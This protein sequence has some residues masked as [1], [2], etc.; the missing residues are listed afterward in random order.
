MAGNSP[1]ADPD[2][3]GSS[4]QSAALDTGAPPSTPCRCP[5]S[6]VQLTN[7]F[8][9]VAIEVY[10]PAEEA[11]ENAQPNTAEKHSTPKAAPEGQEHVVHLAGTEEEVPAALVQPGDAATAAAAAGV[12]GG[13]F[14]ASVSD[15]SHAAAHVPSVIEGAGNDQALVTELPDPEEPDEDAAASNTPA[16]AA[17]TPAPEQAPSSAHADHDTATSDPVAVPVAAHAALAEARPPALTAVQTVAAEGSS[18]GS[19]SRKQLSPKNKEDEIEVRSVLRAV[20]AAHQHI[21]CA[22]DVLSTC[23]MQTLWLLWCTSTSILAHG[24]HSQLAG[25]AVAGQCGACRGLTAQQES[26]QHAEP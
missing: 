23:K 5:G 14:T 16:A 3:T 8:H 13:S 6:W 7:H 18:P 17:P 12:A 26:R 9:S 15:L 25:L 11:Q 19:D 10:V 1:Q 4:L 21:Q 2:K 24:M 22:A 20:P